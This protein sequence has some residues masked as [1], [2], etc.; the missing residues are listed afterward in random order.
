MII[1]NGYKSTVMLSL[2]DLRLYNIFMSQSIFF[3]LDYA[4]CEISYDY[5]YDY[6]YRKEMCSLDESYA[7]SSSQ[8]HLHYT[9]KIYTV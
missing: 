9:R 1:V 4:K 6:Y 5:D 7:P 2:Q 3:M 8:S